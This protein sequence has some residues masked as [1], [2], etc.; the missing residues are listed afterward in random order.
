MAFMLI[1]FLAL[2]ISFVKSIKRSIK[3]RKQANLATHLPAIIYTLTLVLC[4]LIPGSETF[5]SD[6]VIVAGNEG[7]Q[8]QNII[9]FRKNK[10]FEMN[11]TA[12]FGYNE[13]FTGT[14]A[15]KGDTLLLSY[16]TPKPGN[17][18]NKLLETDKELVIIDKPQ[19]KDTAHCCYPFRIYKKA[20]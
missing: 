1:I 14:Y 20:K 7:T 5:E 8:S 17:M 6:A 11:S 3:K 9:K 2:A 4:Y 16:N 13:W 12:V 15:Q 10:T 18:G 19:D